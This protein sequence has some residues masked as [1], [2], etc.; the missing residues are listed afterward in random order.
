MTPEEKAEYTR[1][2]DEQ[3]RRGYCQN[4]GHN[5]ALLADLTAIVCTNRCG[6]IALTGRAPVDLVRKVFPHLTV[7]EKAHSGNPG[8]RLPVNIK[9][10]DVATGKTEDVGTFKHLGGSQFEPTESDDG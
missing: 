5:Y 9:V 3:G 7:L 4:F 6:V 8:Y 1:K 2:R 10:H